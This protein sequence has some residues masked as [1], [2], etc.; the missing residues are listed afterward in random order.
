MSREFG[1]TCKL[2]AFSKILTGLSEGTRPKVL[3]IVEFKVN[4]KCEKRNY[5]TF[6]DDDHVESTMMSR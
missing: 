1:K 5:C 4:R 6:V 2:N 3:Q